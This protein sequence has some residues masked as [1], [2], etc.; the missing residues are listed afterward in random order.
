MLRKKLGLALGWGGARGLAHIG[1]IKGLVKHKIPLDV[2]AGSSMGAL[3]GGLYAARQD[4]NKVDQALGNFDYKELLKTFFDPMMG[5]GL[6]KGEK[7]VQFLK[8]MVQDMKI[9][10]TA[11]AFGAVA[12]DL[13]TAD[14]VVLSDGPLAEAIRASSSVPV[15]FHPFEITSRKLVDGGMSSPVPVETARK[16]GAEIVIAVNLDSIFF[17]PENRKSETDESM[18]SVLWKSQALLRYHLAKKEV[19]DADVVIEPKVV[20]INDLDFSRGQ[21]MVEAGE[22]AVEE[23]MSEIKKL[24]GKS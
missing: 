16:M 6:V 2:I 10:E 20:Y 9:E 19:E 22:Q 14:K 11:I 13:N 4:I 18:V 24:L 15:V 8:Q 17:L 21:L 3:V 1:V 7:L 12:T 5:D 23:K